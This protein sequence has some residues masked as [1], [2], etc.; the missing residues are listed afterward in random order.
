[1]S[2]FSGSAQLRG[3]AALTSSMAATGT[4]AT[5]RR[6]AT[7]ANRLPIAAAQVVAQFL[8]S[9]GLLN[10]AGAVSS[11][12]LFAGVSENFPQCDGTT[13]L[14]IIGIIT[15]VPPRFRYRRITT[16]LEF[17]ITTD[18]DYREVVYG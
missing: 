16:M 13:S 14:A 15:P 18:A 7:V 5:R 17:R 8:T 6:T 11:L 9:I 2:N 12:A 4:T 1:M 10:K 3:V